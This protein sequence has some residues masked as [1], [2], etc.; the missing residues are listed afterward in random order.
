[1]PTLEGPLAIFLKRAGSSSVVRVIQSGDAVPGIPHTRADI[2]SSVFIN[3]AGLVCFQVDYLEGGISKSAILTY[4]RIDLPKGLPS[5][6]TS[7]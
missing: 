2:E 1:M 7:R 5:R 6:R 4:Q 3:S